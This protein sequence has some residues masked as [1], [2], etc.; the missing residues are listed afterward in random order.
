MK[1]VFTNLFLIF[2]FIL[3]SFGLSAQSFPNV[4]AVT[5]PHGAISPLDNL[6]PGY[7][8]KKFII[9]DSILKSFWLDFYIEKMVDNTFSV[10][11]IEKVRVRNSKFVF[12]LIP[13]RKPN[14]SLHLL[15]YTPG[16]S[17]TTFYYPQEGF[18]FKWKYFDPLEKDKRNRIPILLIYEEK[19]N[20]NVIEKKIDKLFKNSK[21]NSIEKDVV[22]KK[23]KPIVTS[24][25][26]LDYEKT[27]L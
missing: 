2:F 13:D 10:Q 4:R 27:P 9:Q 25:M 21:I 22:I 24:F 20:E 16:S 23:L 17:Q 26:L 18:Q 11:K 14:E 5:T 8:S 6:T 7:S 3:I 19:E 1:S 12:E 15:I